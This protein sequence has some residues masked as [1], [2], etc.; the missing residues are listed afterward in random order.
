ME[1]LIWIHHMLAKGT[2]IERWADPDLMI[3]EREGNLL[4]GFND[5]TTHWKSAW[6]RTTF[7]PNVRLH[8]YAAGVGDAARRVVLRPRRSR[9]SAARVRASQARS[10]GPHPPRLFQGRGP[11][12][13]TE[14]SPC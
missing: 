7:G 6:V 8:D 12:R 9:L 14:H 4:A 13:P 10:R 5:N 11:P 3:V 2:V 1:N